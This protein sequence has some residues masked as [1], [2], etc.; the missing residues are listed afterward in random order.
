MMV[1]FLL[2]AVV[3]PGRSLVGPDSEILKKT[4]KEKKA[5]EKARKE[6]NYETE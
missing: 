2:L 1:C 6:A 4:R 5:A 3:H